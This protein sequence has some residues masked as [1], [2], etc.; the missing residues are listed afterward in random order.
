MPT[1]PYAGYIQGMDIRKAN[2]GEYPLAL[3]P[4]GGNVGIGTKAPPQKLS[5]SSGSFWNDGTG[6]G[7]YTS[8]NSTA[9]YFYGNGSNLTAIAS[10]AIDASSVTKQGNVFNGANQ[11]VRLDGDTKLP[12]VDGSALLN[13]PSTEGGAVLA[14]TQTFTGGNTFVQASTFTG[15]VNLPT[16]DKII[17]GNELANSSS[18]V[19]TPDYNTNQTSPV[20]CITNSTIT[21]TTQG[22]TRLAIHAHGM[23][24]NNITDRWNAMIYKIDGVNSPVQIKWDQVSA[25]YYTPY[26]FTAL[27]GILSQGTHSV[28]FALYVQSA[29]TGYLYA[30]IG[31]FWVQELR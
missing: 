11:L 29:S 27:S 21:F 18:T 5:L 15:T 25:N 2:Y 20:A 1:S 13:L 8:G 26:S 6:A 24:N 19:I 9:A 28:C 23:W 17:F 4:T 7:M 30:D 12:A 16:R 3:Q 10:S 14:S 22:G 31:Q